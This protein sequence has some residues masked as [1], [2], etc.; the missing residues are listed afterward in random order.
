MG[1]KRICTHLDN[2]VSKAFDPST[3]DYQL[4][5]K[6]QGLFSGKTT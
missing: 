2:I 6:D 4:S 5:P 3:L 1:N